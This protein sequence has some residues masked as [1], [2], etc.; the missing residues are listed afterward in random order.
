[1]K[2]KRFISV[3]VIVLLLLCYMIFAMKDYSVF[4]IS[5]FWDLHG[6]IAVILI[7]LLVLQATY[8]IKEI[9]NNLKLGFFSS[10]DD[11]KSLK[12]SL[13]FFKHFQKI[14]I[15]TGVL[16]FFVSIM[17]MLSNMS[18][19]YM[20]RILGTALCAVI[21]SILFVLIFFLPIINRLKQRLSILE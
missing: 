5:L 10:N 20:G 15:F 4:V 14:Y 9:A 18:P 16:I 21:Y 13:E 6:F 7:P 11:K 19:E 8:P 3:V 1:M 2:M 17:V 12:R